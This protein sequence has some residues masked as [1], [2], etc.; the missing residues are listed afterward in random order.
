MLPMNSGPLP[1]PVTILAGFLGAGK[2]TML[3]HMLQSLPGRRIAVLQNDFGSIEVITGELDGT[4]RTVEV[5]GH[6][7]VCCSLRNRLYTTLTRLVHAPMPP[8]HIIIEASALADP[9]AIAQLFLDPEL[10][11]TALLDAIFTVLDARQS[12]HMT[13]DLAQLT[14]VQLRAADIILLNKVDLV[15]AEGLRAT[16]TWLES[17]AVTAPII[18]SV[19][20]RIPPSIFSADVVATEAGASPGWAPST[21]MESPPRV[22]NGL[23]VAIAPLPSI[24]RWTYTSDVPLRQAK[25]QA[26]LAGL[27]PASLY[28]VSGVVSLAE[29]PRTLL[30]LRCAGRRMTF[31][32]GGAWNGT[33]HTSLVFTG[34]FNRADSD[35]LQRQLDGCRVSTPS[36][37]N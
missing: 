35:E 34:A 4:T 17:L 32:D 33:P 23:P 10:R 20:G 31:S 7:C 3:N 25:L 30:I 5:L 15:D 19:H 27:L 13:G 14:R 18:E 36:A 24:M 11:R 8:E 6:G 28:R 37:A 29:K 21:A 9:G 2:T 16:R 12:R 26:L 22:A 1:I